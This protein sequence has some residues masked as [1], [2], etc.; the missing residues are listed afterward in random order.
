VTVIAG[1]MIVMGNRRMRVMTMRI[2][3][4]LD[5]IAARIARMRTE[6]RDQPRKDGADQRQKN[7][8]LDHWSASLRMI[9]EQTKAFVRENRFPLFRI[10]PSPSSD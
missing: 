4:M 2:V 1:S 5:G 8:C 6:D 9:S 10:M 3:M 7:D